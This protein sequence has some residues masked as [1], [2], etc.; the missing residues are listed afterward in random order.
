MYSSINIFNNY[1]SGPPVCAKIQVLSPVKTTSIN[2]Y[3]IVIK[4]YWIY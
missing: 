3:L 1:Q 2:S 4:I